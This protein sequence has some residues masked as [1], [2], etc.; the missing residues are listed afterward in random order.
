M[1]FCDT[2]AGRMRQKIIPVGAQNIH[3]HN[4]HNQL[5]VLLSIYYKKEKNVDPKTIYLHKSRRLFYG[6]DS[7][8]LSS[9]IKN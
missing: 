3:N 4:L 1:S 5:L 7:V 8:E 2:N 9:T 6:T